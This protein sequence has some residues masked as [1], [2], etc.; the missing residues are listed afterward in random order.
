MFQQRDKD[1]DDRFVDQADLRR[2]AH[3]GTAD[4]CVFN[5]IQRFVKVRRGVHVNV[6]DAGARFNAGHGGV[7]H[8]GGDQP[9]AA[10]GDQQIHVSSAVHELGSALAGR[11]LHQQHGVRRDARF[12]Y[13]LPQ[14][15]NDGRGGG[16]RLLAAAQDAGVAAF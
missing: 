6:A 5:D 3:G 9:L 1:G 15:R 11:I 7:F 13:S 8:A 2:V 12:F 14:R 10:A 16:V 4:L